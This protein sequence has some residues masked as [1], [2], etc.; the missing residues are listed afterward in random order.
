[1]ADFKDILPDNEDHLN[2]D[3]LMKY[4]EGN[5]SEA[6][7]HAFEEKMQASGFVNDAVDGLQAVK[8][9]QHLYDYVHNLNKTLE[10][11]L[12]AKKQRKEKR[13]IKHISAVILTA[14][15]ILL[16]CIIGY[17]AIHLYHKNSGIQPSPNIKLKSLSL[18]TASISSIG[19]NTVVA[20]FDEAK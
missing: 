17:V 20:V 4:L 11:Q 6:D 18:E 7:K 1:M 10:K 8:N 16:I 5:L 15:I 19:T 9:K 12:A 13:T 2:E 3:E 14:L